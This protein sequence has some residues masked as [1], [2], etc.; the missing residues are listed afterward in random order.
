M[1][2]AGEWVLLQVGWLE[3]LTREG[4]FQQ[5]SEGVSLVEEWR[6]GA[7][8]AEGRASAKALRWQWSRHV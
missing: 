2:G 8:P 4:T 1:R 6:G 3:G 7:F 5:R